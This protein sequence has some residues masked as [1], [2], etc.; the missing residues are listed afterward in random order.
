MDDFIGLI[1]I[2][3]LIIATGAL[4]GLIA[5]IQVNGLKQE[6]AILRAKV[7]KLQASP[8]ADH[9]DTKTFSSSKHVA[10][11]SAQS[12]AYEVEP[13]S[14]PKSNS[15]QNEPVNTVVTPNVKSIKA[16]PAI[17]LF[18]AS[19]FEKLRTGFEQNWMT[20]IGA[21]ALAFGGIF[22][23]KYSLEAGLLSPVMRLSLG[24]LFG[25]GLIIAASY[26]HYKRI[27]FE[28][29]NNYI[30][31][32]LASGGFITCFALTLLAY[33]SYEML[34][35]TTAFIVLAIIAISA[36]I[37]AITLGPLLAVLGI[38]G[39]YSVPIWVNT[40]SSNVF[41]LFMY[42]GFVSLSASLVAHK[43]QRAWLWYLM[44]AGHIGWYL[45]GFII[46]QLK[47]N[48]PWLLATFAL[49]SI[50]GLIALP[51]LGFKLKNIEHRPHSLKRLI[52]VFPDHL[53]LLAF[54]V[55]LI[56]TMSISY[57][58]LEW[59]TIGVLSIGLLLFL[60]L[61]NSR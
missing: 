3:M 18:I 31:A 56:F 36:S 10:P 58:N 22:L 24:G 20:W 4:C 60:V 46:M 53:L 28:G 5:L 15:A 11:L 26:L 34:S 19:V 21:I 59:Q 32:A 51:R 7:V 29:F 42:V 47:S 12:T 37:M 27:I 50:V 9:S 49:L 2:V 1:V 57:Y 13:S 44:W 17:P 35:P 52:K 54:I 39:A 14:V 16:N 43:V 8:S 30:P 40:G 48:T 45:V 23:A 55:P 33:S 25:V 41:A 38:I 61:K 6:I